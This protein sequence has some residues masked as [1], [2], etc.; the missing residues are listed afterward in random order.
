MPSEPITCPIRMA[1]QSSPRE[2][3]GSGEHGKTS[4]EADLREVR[5]GCQERPAAERR[6]SGE[7]LEAAG[8]EIEPR[9]AARGEDPGGRAQ[10]EAETPRLRR[11]ME[12]LAAIISRKRGQR[13]GSLTAYTPARELSASG[14]KER[15]GQVIDINKIRPGIPREGNELAAC[16]PPHQRQ[17]RLPAIPGADDARRA[18]NREETAPR[19]SRCCREVAPPLPPCREHSRCGEAWSLCPPPEQPSST[20]RGVSSWRRAS[21]AGDVLGETDD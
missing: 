9:D 21:S 17:Q 1:P 10:G 8:D 15:C 11:G 16:D 4:P 3:V 14:P 6:G 7:L 2:P 19:S 18:E 5:P 20:G 13:I 12:R